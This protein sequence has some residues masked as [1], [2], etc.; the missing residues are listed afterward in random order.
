MHNSQNQHNLNADS[1]IKIEDIKF[2][3]K[4]KSQHTSSTQTSL[5]L[6]PPLS[7]YIH[8]PWCEKKCPYCD[9]NSHEIKNNK[10]IDKEL[11]NQYIKCLENDIIATLPLI[12][13]RSIH[14]VFIGGGTPSLIS[15]EGMHKI[16]QI[17][18]TLLPM[19]TCIE[20][21]IE[22]NPSSAEISKFHDF[23]QAGINRISLGIQS[24][25]Q[26]HLKILG[27]VHDR[28]QAINAI[29]YAHKFFDNINLD[30]IFALP[31]QTI[32]ECQQD[33]S[34]AISFDTSHLSCYHLTLEP[35]T[36][37]AKYPPPNIP[38][39][40]DAYEM[41]DLIINQLA[42]SGLN[43]YEI[44]AYSKGKHKQSQHNLNYWQ[45]GDYIGIGAGAHGKISFHD[46][47]V[48]YVKQKHPATYIANALNLNDAQN[49]Q[50]IVSQNSISIN[51]LPFEFMLG[52][53][54][55]VDGG[56]VQEF[57]DK[58]SLGYHHIAN[59][60]EIAQNKGLIHK[61]DNYIKPTPLGISFLND[62]Q[63][64]FLD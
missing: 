19:H 10:H 56:S 9:F 31:N 25:N 26:E 42:Q 38:N 14:T 16:L 13:G 39:D 30:I 7:I 1:S 32:E 61:L 21:T 18:F 28:H 46:K 33:I 50:H 11:E 40:D 17:L 64:L 2:S 63:M 44:S 47:I 48:R 59:N 4:S 41:Q 58:T 8:I 6:L 60:I 29:E 36:Y 37:F 12:W 20:I 34:T 49:N 23:K 5:K 52:A 35:N 24:F 57:M 3:S 45:F 53:L 22:A 43:R 55:L 51:E 15:G 62:L 54:R 27:R